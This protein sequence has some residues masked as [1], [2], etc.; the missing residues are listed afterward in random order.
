MG[1]YRTDAWN[2]D[3]F[4]ECVGHDVCS[5]GTNTWRTLNFVGD[6]SV[7]GDNVPNL[8]DEDAA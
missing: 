1:R 2:G 5:V 3:E 4:G 8:K 7:W 6:A